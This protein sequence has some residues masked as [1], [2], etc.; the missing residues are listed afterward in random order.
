LFLGVIPNFANAALFEIGLSTMG[1]IAAAILY[2][3]GTIGGVFVWLAGMFTNWA[4]NLNST[5]LDSPIVNI[6]WTIS[7]DI[8]N[9]GFVLAIILIA[10]A[11]ILRLENYQMKKTL[12]RLI[13]AALLI[14]FSL[15]FAGVF[16]DF[17]GML[18]NFFL[19]KATG[20]NPSQIGVLMA[21][22][23]NVQQ[24]LG[25]TVP[26]DK[27]SEKVSGLTSNFN[28]VV[29]FVGS[30][31][32]VSFFTAIAAI[33]LLGFA[34]MIFVRYIFLNILLIIMPIAW[35]LWVWPD[36]SKYW[37]E[38]WNNFFKWTF[39]LPA[40]SFFIYLA[41]AITEASNA[42]FNMSTTGSGGMLVDIGGIL[43]QMTAVIG[44]LVGGLMASEKFGIVGAQTFSAAAQGVYKNT[45]SYIGKKTKG[46]INVRGWKDMKVDKKA[47]QFIQRLQGLRRRIGEGADKRAKA[48]EESPVVKGLTYIPG[49]GLG[50]S[51]G[52]GIGQDLD[53]IERREKKKKKTKEEIKEEIKE[54]QLEKE[55]E[56]QMKED[57]R[58]KVSGFKPSNK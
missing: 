2:I 8:A 12:L 37:N 20:N 36:T 6:G 15:V 7:R 30:L 28:S 50:A 39:F 45:G 32:F 11:T 58:T 55:I 34:F 54:K 16:L 51:V 49:F 52:K 53:I 56:D 29:P 40:A 41:L 4:F 48:F 57:E 23:M 18:G 5:I 9:L 21:G 25:K 46:A 42:T 26:E 38:W 27:I 35:L 19:S 17:S 43:G 47:P 10:F 1:K 33:T 3:V 13:A 24:I 22:S 14:N 31:F 44:I